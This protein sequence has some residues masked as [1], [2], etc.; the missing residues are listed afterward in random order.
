MGLRLL[1]DDLRNIRRVRGGRYQARA[2]HAGHRYNLGCFRTADAARAAL[3][4]FWRDSKDTGRPKFVRPV[5]VADPAGG[6]RVAYY[7]RVRH[8]RR[9]YNLG[10]FRTLAEAGT[11]VAMFVAHAFPHTAHAVLARG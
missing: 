7:A 1:D 10:R 6:Y 5:R 8:D 9:E 2:T 11:A 3:V 4:Q